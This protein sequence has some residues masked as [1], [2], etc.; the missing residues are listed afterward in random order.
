MSAGGSIAAMI[1]SMK[2]NSRRKNK[3]IPF[4]QNL[5]NYKKGKPISSK[6]M[7]PKEKDLLLK[8]LKENKEKE[9]K[10]HIYKLIITLFLTVAVISGIVFILKF[11]F[12]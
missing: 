5:N 1:S 10:T 2:N 12:F 4:S 9:S 3:H 8:K 6:E 7:T 11:T